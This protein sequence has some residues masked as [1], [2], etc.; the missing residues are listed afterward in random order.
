MNNYKKDLKMLKKKKYLYSGKK[1]RNI[2][3]KSSIIN[4]PKKSCDSSLNKISLSLNELIRYSPIGR[5][6]TQL[7]ITSLL[8]SSK[9]IVIN[10]EQF[11]SSKMFPKN[12][13]HFYPYRPNSSIINSNLSHCEERTK[14]ILSSR[15]NDSTY[16]KKDCQSPKGAFSFDMSIP[17]IPKYK[18]HNE[19]YKRIKKSK[20]NIN[21]ENINLKPSKNY[22]LNK[23]YNIEVCKNNT[24]DKKII[25]DKSPLD[26]QKFVNYID[27]INKDNNFIN[28]IKNELKVYYFMNDEN[29]I[30]TKHYFEKLFYNYRFEDHES[31]LNDF[32][33]V[34]RNVLK[35][36]NLNITLK[37][38][39]LQFIFYEITEDEIN[40]KNIDTNSFYDI[41][42]NTNIKYNINSK[43]NFPFEFLSV[44][45]GINYQE[46]IN[47]LLSMIEFDFINN[48]FK[49]DHQTFISKI[50]MGKTLYDFYTE[51]SYFSLNINDHTLNKECYLYDWDV[52]NANNK[53]VKHFVLKI[54]LPQQKITI[55]CADKTKIKFFSTLSI[56]NNGDLLKNS[57]YKWDYLILMNFS[58]YKI[59]RYEINKL[60]C[61]KYY[62][63]SKNF[64]KN[65]NQFK[66]NKETKKLSF[67]LNKLTIILNTIKKNNQSYGFF[68]SHNKGKEKETYYISLKLP[69]IK[70]SYQNVVYSFQ[71]K[72]N[73]DIK[74]LSQL[75][76]LSKYFCPE[77]IIKYSMIIKKSKFREEKNIGKKKLKRLLSLKKPIKVPCKRSI[78]VKEVN[79]ISSNLKKES[80]N[81]NQNEDGKIKI[82]KNFNRNDEVIKD[83]KLDIDK[84]IFNFDESIFKYIKL[85][86]NIK[87]NYNDNNKRDKGITSEN[88]LKYNTNNQ[89]NIETIKN[90]KTFDIEIGNI[91]L[92]WTNQ[93]ALTKNIKLDKK[94]TEYLLDYP[95]SKWKI[96]VE[97]NIETL[98][99]NDKDIIKPIRQSS[100][101]NLVW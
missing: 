83:I 12:I 18:V 15:I 2:R 47:L 44:F 96:F 98:L 4:S 58:E 41:E 19:R 24:V 43:I 69:Q 91:E 74:R 64:P 33:S 90:L 79:K 1:E 70:I 63:M 53:S 82:N 46:F 48:K 31:F 92:S 86:E 40:K 42:N 71:K 30:G 9:G 54:V 38:T 23:N 60:L 84:Y 72:F 75:N 85:K 68:Y 94:D 101:N 37:I 22:F 55:K 73:L 21:E 78:S 67:N 56:K 49:I 7:M 14:F 3:P 16:N 59:F 34:K 97:Q 35:I 88:N 62:T 20:L 28:K 52:K 66:Y 8:S 13:H 10:K 77:D 29:Y 100:K 81:L 50:E 6:K 65:K 25:D 87:K 61:G 5:N 93:E 11:G 36:D 80:T 57:F 32:Y 99:S 26:E 17:A 27:E 51:L 95:T 89:K 39:S 76:K 45:Y